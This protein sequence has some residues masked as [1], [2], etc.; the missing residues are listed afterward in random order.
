[1]LKDAKVLG[2]AEAGSCR[3]GSAI[4]TRSRA[5]TVPVWKRSVTIR[6]V[7]EVYLVG[8]SSAAKY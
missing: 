3:D 1:M 8:G 6:A 7:I 4:T 5:F 2:A